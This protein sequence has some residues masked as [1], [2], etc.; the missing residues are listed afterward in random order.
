MGDGEGDPTKFSIYLFQALGIKPFQIKVPFLYP[1]KILE[2]QRFSDVFR[3]CRN[4][5]LA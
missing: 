2:N 1:L 5:I 4:E 3:K